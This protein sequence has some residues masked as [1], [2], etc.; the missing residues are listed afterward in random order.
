MAVSTRVRLNNVLITQMK[1]APAVS[2][3]QRALAAYLRSEGLAYADILRELAREPKR[4][5]A[6]SLGERIGAFLNL[7]SRHNPLA[8]IRLSV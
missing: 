5:P 6:P 3:E 2:T 1:G 8:S 4:E 7:V